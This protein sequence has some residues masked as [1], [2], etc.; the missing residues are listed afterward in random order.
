MVLLLLTSWTSR[1]LAQ[2]PTTGAI[3]GVVRDA[4]TRQ[5][6]TGALV[7]LTSEGANVTI[8]LIEGMFGGVANLLN[9]ENFRQVPSVVNFRTGQLF[10]TLQ[11]TFPI[12]PSIGLTLEF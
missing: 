8:P 7:E 10:G 9:R 11:S 1:T 5:P 12:L 4:R 3:A 6:L 2:Q